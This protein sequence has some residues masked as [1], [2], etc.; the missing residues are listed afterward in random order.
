MYSTVWGSVIIIWRWLT[1]CDNRMSCP[2]IVNHLDISKMDV[3]EKDAVCPSRILTVVERQ[4]DDVLEK[5]RVLKRLNWWV[6]IAL[7]WQ[8][9][10]FQYGPFRVE[11]ISFVALACEAIL[12]QTAVGAG[13]RPATT[14]QVEAQ[15]LTSSVAPCTRIGTFKTRQ[16]FS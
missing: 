4:S 10:A 11:Q 7:I 2:V 5:C 3:T 8:M 6:Q 1:F 12:R 9:N 16:M 14:A 13:A 15:L